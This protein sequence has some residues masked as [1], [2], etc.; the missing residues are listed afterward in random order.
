MINVN[1]QGSVVRRPISANSEV[2]FYSGFLFLLLENIFS[3][4]FIKI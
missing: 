4:D 3:G 1:G 2:K